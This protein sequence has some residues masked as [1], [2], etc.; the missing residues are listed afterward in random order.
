ML[1]AF[2]PLFLRR[3]F[4]TQT[5]HTHTHPNTQDAS[6]SPTG[7]VLFF[8]CVNIHYVCLCRACTFVACV[9]SVASGAVWRA[10]EASEPPRSGQSGCMY[11]HVYAFV[12]I[13]MKLQL[14][15]GAS[16]ASVSGERAF[17]DAATAASEA[18]GPTEWPKR[19]CV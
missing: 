15:V 13:F 8:A 16:E 18:S 5:A 12:C 2:K 6:T 1:R 9:A 10:S 14:C 7:G 11:M 4:N 19:G 3:K 17:S